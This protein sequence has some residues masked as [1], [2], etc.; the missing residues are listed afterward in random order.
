MGKMITLV[1][2]TAPKNSVVHIF[3]GSDVDP[4]CIF[5][6]DQAPPP[7]APSDN[8]AGD[9]VKPRFTI[10]EHFVFDLQQTPS[11]QV[12][13]TLQQ[14]VFTPALTARAWHAVWSL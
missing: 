5:H 14:V 6:F 8:I 9:T 2:D 4:S 3:Q 12:S 1:V 7:Q 13:P 10:G 11:Q